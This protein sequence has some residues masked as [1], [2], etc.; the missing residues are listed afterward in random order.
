MLETI[1][2]V[3]SLA[4]AGTA[5]VWGYIKSRRFVRDR[6]KFVDAAQKKST[7]VIAGM[8]TGL[9]IT[10]LAVLPLVDVGTAVVVGIAVG[11]GVNRGRKDIQ[12]YLRGGTD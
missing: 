12:R 4:V 9:L 6:L 5:S 10:P 2:V 11:A 1:G 7:A 3:G 8:G